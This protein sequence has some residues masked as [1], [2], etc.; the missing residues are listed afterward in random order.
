[1]PPESTPK[2][3]NEPIPILYTISPP[4]TANELP[5]YLQ[6]IAPVI[7]HKK[8]HAIS[9]PELNNRIEENGS[10]IYQPTTIPPEDFLAEFPKNFDLV[11]TFVVPRIPKDK[12]LQRLEY[13]RTHGVNSTILVGPEKQSDIKALGGYSVQEGFEIATQNNF[14]CGGITIPWRKVPVSTSS[15]AKPIPEHERIAL[16]QKYGCKFV[17]SQLVFEFESPSQLIYDY[18]NYCNSLFIKLLH[19]S[20]LL[21]LKLI[22]SWPLS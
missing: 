12:F 15:T 13:M 4:K 9:S 5:N 17:T 16:K 7:S 6:V 3:L 11:S 2:F 14:A 8:I 22:P 20:N 21:L 10:V 19:T 18:A 1:M